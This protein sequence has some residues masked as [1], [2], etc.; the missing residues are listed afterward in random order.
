MNRGTI[1]DEILRSASFTDA[2]EAQLNTRIELA[3]L[4][5]AHW[6]KLITNMHST[7]GEQVQNYE[8]HSLFLDFDNEQPVTYDDTALEKKD[9][10]WLKNEY[11]DSLDSDTGTPLYWAVDEDLISI[12]LYP[13]PDSDCTGNGEELVIPSILRPTELSSDDS[14]PWNGISALYPYH[15]LIVNYVCYLEEVALGEIRQAESSFKIDFAS[16]LKELAYV[17]KNLRKG[18]VKTEANI[19]IEDYY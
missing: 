18:N 9:L 2:T 15:M 6:C 5:I 13:I 17:V 19:N 14:I 7:T 1:R 3:H 12:N 16:E 10:W 11:G 4:K 8:L